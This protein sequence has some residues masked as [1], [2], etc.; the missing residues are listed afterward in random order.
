[1]IKELPEGSIWSVGGV[2]NSQLKMNTMA[3][4]VGGGVR[5]GLEDN[6]WFDEERTHLA[7]NTDLVKRIC[8][9]AETLGRTPY[10]HKKARERLGV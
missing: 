3:L 7:T 4:V 9:I 8:K 10:T 6:I 5:V 2:G 1:M